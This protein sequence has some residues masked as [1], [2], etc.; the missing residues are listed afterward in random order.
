MSNKSVEIQQVTENISVAGQI[1]E[2]QIAQLSEL[3]FQAVLNVRS[4]QENGTLPDEQRQVEAL[5]LPYVNLP[6]S[7][8][9]LDNTLINHVVE[10]IN[11]LPKPLLVHC[12]SAL[13]ATFMVMLYR[14]TREGLSLAAAKAEAAEL[15]FD[16]DHNPPLKAAID[17][18]FAS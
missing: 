15:G 16:I 9:S 11:Q 6:V 3:G 8:Q 2:A 18:Y 14:V 1:S 17:N 4:P 10:Q 13:R 12:G 7:L 5:G